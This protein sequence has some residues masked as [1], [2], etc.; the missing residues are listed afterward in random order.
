MVVTVGPEETGNGKAIVLAVKL[1]LIPEQGEPIELEPLALSQ[2]A[3]VDN[4]ISFNSAFDTKSVDPQCLR[5]QAD[6]LGG[7]FK[8]TRMQSPDVVRLRDDFQ[9]PA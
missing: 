7:I 4:E 8:A 1:R 2:P 9:Q 3:A 5:H 6:A